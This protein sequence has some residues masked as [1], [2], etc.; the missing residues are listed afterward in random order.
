MIDS[1]SLL[2]QSNRL[3]ESLR[4]ES[5]HLPQ[6]RNDTQRFPKADIRRN[7]VEFGPIKI[8]NAVKAAVRTKLER[9]CLRPKRGLRRVSVVGSVG[10]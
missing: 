8:G 2:N 10:W 3:R 9:W 6:M 4:A 1:T 7:C 5:S